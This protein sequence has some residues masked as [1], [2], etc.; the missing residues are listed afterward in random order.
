M[1]TPWGSANARRTLWEKY[2]VYIG[3]VYRTMLILESRSAQ[4][5][6]FCLSSK[7]VVWIRSNCEIRR[8][9]KSIIS[10]K[11]LVPRSSAWNQVLGTK[12]LVPWFQMP[13]Q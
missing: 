2:Q 1:L 6:G 11:Y 5:S 3:E 10:T 8:R 13:A 4:Y 9:E 12:Y 7:I